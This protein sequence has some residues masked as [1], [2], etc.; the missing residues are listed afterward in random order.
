MPEHGRKDRYRTPSLMHATRLVLV[1]LRSPLWCPCTLLS[2]RGATHIPTCS[3]WC[4]HD[5]RSFPQCPKSL[6]IPS[7]SPDLL[8]CFCSSPAQWRCAKETST[9]VCPSAPAVVLQEVLAAP[10]AP[11]SIPVFLRASLYLLGAS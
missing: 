9:A 3:F 6:H 7:G 4:P 8:V 2:F 10:R 11:V 1:L 5:L